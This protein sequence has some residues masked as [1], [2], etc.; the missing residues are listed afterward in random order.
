MVF[1]FSE[2]TKLISA[3]GSLILVAEPAGTRQ[4]PLP[5][6]LPVCDSSQT[7]LLQKVLPGTLKPPIF[8]FFI[9]AYTKVDSLCYKAVSFDD[10]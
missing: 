5:L 9:F 4:K 8:F 1:L 6:D 10:V 3:S 7:F 2:S